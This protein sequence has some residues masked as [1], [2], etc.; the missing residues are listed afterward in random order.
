MRE[1]SITFLIVLYFIILF[2]NKNPIY[3]RISMEHF[4]SKIH[5]NFGK[6]QNSSMRTLQQPVSRHRHAISEQ[7]GTANDLSRI[8]RNKT[9]HPI[10]VESRVHRRISNSWKRLRVRT[11]FLPST[12]SL[13]GR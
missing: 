3:T 8:T 2:F 11:N 1:V 5:L 7:D 9:Y 13:H 10:I 12:C 6:K 4:F